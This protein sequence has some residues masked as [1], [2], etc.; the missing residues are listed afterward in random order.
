MNCEIGIITTPDYQPLTLSATEKLIFYAYPDFELFV[1]L[2]T[3]T[4]GLT[5]E[6]SVILNFS[7][8]KTSA[9]VFITGERVGIY[10]I[11][12]EISGRSATQ[13][14]QPQPAS[15]IIK[16]D[17]PPAP[18]YFTSRDLEPGLLEAESCAFATPLDYTC[19]KENQQISFSSTCRWYDN[20]SP[21]IIFSEYNDLILPVAIT[22][23]RISNV[24]T[25]DQSRAIPLMGNDFLQQCNFDSPQASCNFKPSD[26]V[27]EV[28]NFLMTE[29]LGH[30]FLR[31]VEQLIPPWLILSVDTSTSRTHDSTSYMIDLVESDFLAETEG[32][33]GLFRVEDGIYAVLKYSGSLNFNVN[34]SMQNFVPQES[35][36]CFAINLCEGLNSPLTVAIP[37]EVQTIVNSLP[38]TQIIR[39]YGW[40]FTI[41]SI[42]IST[43][44]FAHELAGSNNN[45]WFGNQEAAY[46]YP[47]ST[48]IVDGRF[49]HSF[50]LDT[51]QINY[52][53]D[54]DAYMM[55]ND[56]NKV[57]SYVFC[58]N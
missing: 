25:S 43:T 18:E 12:Y 9:E 5:I 36:I 55:Y 28:E 10:T 39:N 31:Q 7:P 49:D 15:I 44:P 29:A 19:P 56:L 40:E 23:T 16:E 4:T 54:G 30:T 11:I 27:N 3:G 48:I 20:A 26:H 53:L 1:E 32:C 45:Y 46:A 58:A 52:S 21:G 2:I 41:N 35:H 37:N 17:T 22:G 34:S 47:D 24:T 51:L 50:S 33:A 13:F 6:P 14:Q 57:G 8:S 42:A 38:F